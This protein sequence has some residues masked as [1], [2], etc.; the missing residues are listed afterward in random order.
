MF[1]KVSQRS[2]EKSLWSR[3]TTVCVEPTFRTASQKLCVGIPLVILVFL[4]TGCRPVERLPLAATRSSIGARWQEVVMPPNSRLLHLSPD[5]HWVIYGVDNTSGGEQGWRCSLAKIEDDGRLSS[6]TLITESTKETIVAAHGFSPDSSSFLIETISNK[7]QLSETGI[8]LN[9]VANVRDQLLVYTG[10][11]PLHGVS[12]APDSRHFTV[13]T[14]DMGADLV[15]TD[16]TVRKHVV[17]PATFAKVE[18]SLSWS[19]VSDQIVYPDMHKS[20]VTVWMAD[21]KSGERHSLFSDPWPVKPIWSPDGQTIAILGFE[22]GENPEQRLT[23]LNR[24]GQV[25]ATV[26]LPSWPDYGEGMWSPDGKRFALVL[27][28]NE[29]TTETYVAV[30]SMPAG[31][32]SRFPIEKGGSGHLRGWDPDSQ[33]VIVETDRDNTPVLVRVP[34]IR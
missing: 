14:T 29:E 15:A 20:P 23:M 9:Q 6:P 10:T 26:D 30:V 17:P 22:P 13:V 12:W 19:P 31:R 8:W 24:D 18:T 33:S 7:G 2:S 3:W 21:L 4:F 32:Y 28:E 25:L 27:K 5:L 34:V 11:T 1:L 16:G